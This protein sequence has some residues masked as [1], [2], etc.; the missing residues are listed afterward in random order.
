MWRSIFVEKAFVNLVKW[1]IDMRVV[2]LLRSTY[3]VE[4]CAGS[5]F[6]LDWRFHDPGAFG[7]AVATLRTVGRRA[8]DFDQLRIV[9]VRAESAFARSSRARWRRR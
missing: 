4:I 5:G 2:R 3:D 9:N 8:I 1:R 7:R 6:P